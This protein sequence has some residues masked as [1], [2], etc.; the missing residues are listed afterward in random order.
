MG[1]W[2]IHPRTTVLRGRMT[3]QSCSRNVSQGPKRLAPWS[4]K[5]NISGT[6]VLFRNYRKWPKHSIWPVVQMK[7]CSDQAS[8]LALRWLP[9]QI[10]KWNRFRIE[11]LG[12]NLGFGHISR[13][14]RNVPRAS[15]NERMAPVSWSI[16]GAW[17]Q[18]SFKL[19][20]YVFKFGATRTKP[21]H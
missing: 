13:T 5:R 6:T 8:N 19:A 10:V 21:E 11:G 14:C 7:Q 16:L 9:S 18:K 15:S 1:A 12:S 4:W 20:T 17:W 3:F 2:G